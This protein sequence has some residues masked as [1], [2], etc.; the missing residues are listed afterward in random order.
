MLLNEVQKQHAQLREQTARLDAQQ[1][2]LDE[3]R[4][5]VRALVGGKAAVRE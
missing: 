2:E 4:A 3:L 1:R 5:Q